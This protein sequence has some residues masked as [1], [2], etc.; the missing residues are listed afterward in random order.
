MDRKPELG[1]IEGIPASEETLVPSSGFTGSVMERVSA[2]SNVLP[3]IPFPWKRAL[4]AIALAVGVFGWGAYEMIRFASARTI[5]L[6]PLHLSAAA[7]NGL[8][9]T[10]WVALALGTSM[11]A[12]LVSRRL[13]GREGLL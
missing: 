7:I 10:G 3:P 2:E 1:T 11:L 8:E 5:L 6:A 12:W 9:S 13:V 4:P